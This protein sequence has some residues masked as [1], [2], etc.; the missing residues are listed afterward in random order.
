MNNIYVETIPETC[1]DCEF[2]E[3]FGKDAHGKGKHEVACYFNGFL[4]N[5]ILGDTINAKHCSHLK[6]LT[7]R[8]AEEKQ[9]VVTEIKK[10]FEP[11]PEST[12][13][14]GTPTPEAE[15]V[16]RGF[17]ACKRRFYEIFDKV[18]RGE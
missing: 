12:V 5:A 3:H 6:L 17:R 9:K 18:E 7:D 15:L 8:L 10:Q 1:E 16:N 11:S 14:T 13:I 2:C 4:T